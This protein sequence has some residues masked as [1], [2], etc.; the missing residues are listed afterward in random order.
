MVP[1]D[2]TV[3]AKFGLRSNCSKKLDECSFARRL[4]YQRLFGKGAFSPDTRNR[5]AE[6]ELSLPG[7]R[8]RTTADLACVA[9]A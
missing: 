4:D 7:I 8:D 1:F 2:L 6:I 3:L 5:A 9:G